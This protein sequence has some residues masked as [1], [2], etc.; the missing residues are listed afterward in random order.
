[1]K[2]R[3]L[4]GYALI[5]GALIFPGFLDDLVAVPIGLYLIDGA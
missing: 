5:A 3:A 2:T 1:M 4:A